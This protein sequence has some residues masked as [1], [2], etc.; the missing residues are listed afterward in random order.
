[1]MSDHGVI[2][3]ARAETHAGG[4]EAV[5]ERF[6]AVHHDLMAVLFLAVDELERF[7]HVAERIG[8]AGMK[9]RERVVQD[10]RVLAGETFA[11][12]L[13]QLRHVQVE[14][15][16]DQAE[17]ENVLALVLGRAADGL[18]RQRR[19]SERRRGDNPPAIP[20]SATTWS[21]S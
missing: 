20:A 4:D 12:E 17:G 15:F 10:A 19:K 7:Q 11:D 3:I 9:R 6:V 16:G 18:D 14:H 8:V 5:A 13:F 2:G 21:E 1:M